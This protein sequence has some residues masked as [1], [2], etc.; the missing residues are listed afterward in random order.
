MKK[1]SSVYNKHIKKITELKTTK[2]RKKHG[3]YIAE[4]ERV[5][6]GFARNN[7]QPLEIFVIQEKACFAQNLFK[8]TPC[9]IV[10]ESVMKKISCATTPSGALALFSSLHSQ[11]P[12][13]IDGPALVLCNSSDPGNM[14]TLIRSAVACGTSTLILIGGCDPYNPKVIQS[15]AGTIAGITILQLTLDQLTFY[16]KTHTFCA[17][18]IN[19]GTSLTSITTKNILLF[20]G[21]EAHGLSKKEERIC[22]IHVTLPMH[23]KAESFNAAVAGSIALFMIHNL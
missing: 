11:A 9:F 2:G 19:N 15:S 1:I 6:E 12:Q 13:P 4:G 20:I 5:L 22:D 8:D 23:K 16:K 21:N 18:V 10:T 3:L 17:L 14:G 7:K